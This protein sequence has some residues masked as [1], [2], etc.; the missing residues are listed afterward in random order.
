M[1]KEERKELAAIICQACERVWQAIG[2][3]VLAAGEGDASA[4]LVVEMCVD[5]DRLKMF[6]EPDAVAAWELLSEDMNGY[7]EQLQFVAGEM[8]YEAYC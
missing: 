6:G 4:E 5:A 2:H 1:T 3:D 8:L 7:A